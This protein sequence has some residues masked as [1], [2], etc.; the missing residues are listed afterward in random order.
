MQLHLLPQLCAKPPHLTFSPARV[1]SDLD[2]TFS[3]ARAPEPT[4]TLRP[5]SPLAPRAPAAAPPPGP[6]HRPAA[7][8]S[9]GSASPPAR[10]TPHHGG[11]AL[12]PETPD[13]D[14]PKQLA[15]CIDGVRQQ[16]LNKG[17]PKHVTLW[18]DGARQ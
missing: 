18:I 12:T 10:A 5:H 7:P 17:L 8:P 11:H 6:L 3:P 13:W 15:V 9:A 2:L 16:T 4:L 14:A 1:H